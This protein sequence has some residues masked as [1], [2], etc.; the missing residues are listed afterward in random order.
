MKSSQKYKRHV[1][2]CIAIFCIMFISYSS[3][4]QTKLII[5]NGYSF[6]YEHLP[7]NIMVDR[8]GNSQKLKIDTT[9]ILYIETNT[10]KINWEIA[11]MD[12]ISYDIASQLIVQTPFI[13]GNLKNNN[14]LITIPIKKNTFLWQIYLTS[15]PF[16]KVKLSSN[17]TNEIFIKGKYKKKSFIKKCGKLIQL[18]EIP[19]V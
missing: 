2:V 11:G 1:I 3:F 17:N 12:G 10:N 15:I 5:N 18:A 9:I 6:F 7:G 4:G 14:N 13:V 8:D 19:S 16:K